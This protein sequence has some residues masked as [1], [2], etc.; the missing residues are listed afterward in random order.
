MLVYFAVLCVSHARHHIS[1]LSKIAAASSRQQHTLQEL[2]LERGK[3]EQRLV[4]C[5][6]THLLRVGLLGPALCTAMSA[7]ALR[8]VIIVCSR[9]TPP[10]V[11]SWLLGSS[12]A[13]ARDSRPAAARASTSSRHAATSSLLSQLR[14]SR[15]EMSCMQVSNT[16]QG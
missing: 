10:T 14:K 4:L 2:C 11:A 3:A 13:S 16:E 6:F 7:L 15:M 8:K 9:P 1:M 5:T 12:V